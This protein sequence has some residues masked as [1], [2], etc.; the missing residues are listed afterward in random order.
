MYMCKSKFL[1]IFGYTIMYSVLHCGQ[2]TWA[3]ALPFCF[4]ST[5]RCMHLWCTHFVVPL[6]WQGLTHEA[7]KSSSSVAKHTQQY[8]LLLKQQFLIK[9]LLLIKYYR[10]YKTYSSSELNCGILAVVWFGD[11]APSVI[12]R[13]K[14][15][16]VISDIVFLVMSSSN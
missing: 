15:G 9:Y 1:P 16:S 10:G 8:L 6:Q 11:E 3:P 5:H 4:S 7:V 2:A 12:S 14:S 13:D